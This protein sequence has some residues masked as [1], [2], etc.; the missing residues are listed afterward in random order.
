MQGLQGSID[1]NTIK[2]FSQKE[3]IALEYVT[4]LSKTPILLN[5][6]L[7][8]DLRSLFSERQIVAIA[9]LCAKVNY[10]TRL[11]EALRVKPAGFVKDPI[12]N[13]DKCNTWVK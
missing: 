4:K 8:D 13:L 2:S 5:Q 10:W 3:K 1:I 7:L 11:I 12:L 9:A 6:K